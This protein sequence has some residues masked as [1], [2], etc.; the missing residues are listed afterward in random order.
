MLPGGM[1][2]AQFAFVGQADALCVQVWADVRVVAAQVLRRHV[3]RRLRDQSAAETSHAFAPNALP[4]DEAI[5][6]RLALGECITGAV[7]WR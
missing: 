5:A 7:V 3:F 2:Q 1:L 4:V 6:L